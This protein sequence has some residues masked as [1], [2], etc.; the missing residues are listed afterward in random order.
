MEKILSCATGTNEDGGT[1]EVYHGNG[2]HLNKSESGLS[3]T[4][5]NND[6]SIKEHGSI[7]N[8][9]GLTYYQKGHDIYYYA[10]KEEQWYHSYPIY[11]DDGKVIDTKKEKSFAPGANPPSFS[12]IPD[13]PE[14]S[15]NSSFDGIDTGIVPEAASNPKLMSAAQPKQ[16]V[17]SI[18]LSNIVEQGVHNNSANYKAPSQNLNQE[19][20]DKLNLSETEIRG[21]AI[22][23]FES[24]FKFI[25]E[26]KAQS[27]KA[28]GSWF[29][30]D[31]MAEY[32]ID[33]YEGYIKTLKEVKN[34]PETFNAYYKDFTGVDFNSG[35]FVQQINLVSE[36]STL[37]ATQDYLTD[38]YNKIPQTLSITSELST[39]LLFT[40]SLVTQ[41]DYENVKNTV[42]SFAK[43]FNPAG[44]SVIQS[45]F[46]KVFEM[47]YGK[48]I[49]TAT[50]AEKT[51]YYL[52]ILHA[53]DAAKISDF[54][55]DKIVDI[56]TSLMEKFDKNKT[57]LTQMYGD[58]KNTDYIFDRIK[59]NQAYCMGIYN[60]AKIGVTMAAAVIGTIA[61][62]GIAGGAAIAGL[63]TMAITGTELQDENGNI[64]YENLQKSA[65]EG[66]MTALYTLTGGIVGQ[67]MTALG[68][69]MTEAGFSTLTTAIAANGLEIADQALIGY[70][71][72]LALRGEADSGSEILMATIG[73]TLPIAMSASQAI[74]SILKNKE[75]MELVKSRIDEMTKLGQTVEPIDILAVSKMTDVEFARIQERGLNTQKYGKP[76]SPEEQVLAA[77]LSDADFAL[78]QKLSTIEGLDGYDM[79][80][81]IERN[82]KK[83]WNDDTVKLIQ[84]AK[85]KTEVDKIKKYAEA[86]GDISIPEYLLQ[87]N[88][89]EQQIK[90]INNQNYEINPLLLDDI[91]RLANGETSAVKSRSYP[92]TEAG[93]TAV[94]KDINIKPFDVV[95]LEGT[96]YFR[97]SDSLVELYITKEAYDAL[98][99][100]GDRYIINQ[101]NQGICWLNSVF[102][103]AE[104]NSKFM[105]EI[106]KTLSM[107]GENIQCTLGGDV[108]TSTVETEGFELSSNKRSNNC[109]G[110]QL[111]EETVANHYEQIF[112]KIDEDFNSI[113][114]KILTT[115]DLYDDI[116]CSEIKELMDDMKKYGYNN[117]GDNWVREA[118][119]RL[120]KINSLEST[121]Q[122]KIDLYK[123]TIAEGKQILEETVDYDLSLEIKDKHREAIQNAEEN[124]EYW[125][126]LK[127]KISTTKSHYEE[128]I[129]SWF[130]NMNGR[131]DEYKFDTNI[132]DMEFISSGDQSHNAS[133]ILLDLENK[134]SVES[135]KDIKSGSTGKIFTDPNVEGK[136]FKS[137][138]ENELKSLLDSGAIVQ[139]NTCDYRNI[140][141]KIFVDNKYTDFGVK[142]VLDHLNGPHAIAVTGYDSSTGTVYIRNTH[143]GLAGKDLPISIEELSYC[144]Y[145]VGISKLSE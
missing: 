2:L 66:E 37:S 76:L 49:D 124:L 134:G 131:I 13:I 114:E 92:N 137:L 122:Q 70:L 108:Y 55:G 1:W 112:Q 61:T 142:F 33:E 19:T 78:A 86:L 91:H 20:L 140:M 75:A 50:L 132:I 82:I 96:L 118:I 41:E 138:F 117:G 42:I 58:L 123:K 111:I 7:D 107:K 24:V 84:E 113:A 35:N 77:K 25:E 44:E 67:Q 65:F 80:N 21:I 129:D 105:G 4:I 97:D 3:W 135:L 23:Y 40:P 85:T 83:G 72:N 130:L 46:E 89:S 36:I 128:V 14:F 93:R 90:M 126:S 38:L 87:Y 81:I 115:G 48:T 109:K 22:E 54:I 6:G 120:E 12:G 141:E 68:T 16:G 73:Q 94:L 79:K 29:S 15:G 143:S 102:N 116:M 45:N 28:L 98:F 63:T 136:N 52:K 17:G 32:K 34:D 125:L 119:E 103:S 106:L 133:A 8:A 99:P 71:E 30:Q 57:L 69:A 18:K 139:I 110:F 64:S 26:Q 11:D 59:S 95:E 101:G 10:V 47:Q 9:I 31:A 104:A 43:I 74:K 5:E 51:D 144:V 53:Y 88:L 60:T 62:G 39:K 56:E 121:A 145:S 27:N 127:E 100:L